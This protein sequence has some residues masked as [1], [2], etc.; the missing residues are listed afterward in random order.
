MSIEDKKQLG[1][2]KQNLRAFQPISE[3]LS[4]SMGVNAP[5]YPI[6]IGDSFTP[7]NYGGLLN[8][9]KN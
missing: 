7:Y 4:S 8:E 6:F 5:A 1:L 9:I 2:D 3:S